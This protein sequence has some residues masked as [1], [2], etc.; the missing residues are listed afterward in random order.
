MCKRGADRRGIGIVQLHGIQPFG[1][2]PVDIRLLA[3]SGEHTPAARLEAMRRVVA[4]TGGTA[5]DENCLVA[6]AAFMACVASR[7]NSLFDAA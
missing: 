3:A 5:G 2:E 4:N 1:A 6:H 7:C